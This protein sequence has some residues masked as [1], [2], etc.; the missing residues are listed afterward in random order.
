MYRH[1][2]IQ[3]AATYAGLFTLLGLSAKQAA[4]H[5]M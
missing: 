1:S 5:V 3:H 4:K 2:D